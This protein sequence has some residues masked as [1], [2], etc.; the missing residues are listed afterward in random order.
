[1][2][3]FQKVGMPACGPT[4]SQDAIAKTSLFAFLTKKSIFIENQK[5]GQARDAESIQDENENGKKGERGNRVPL[6]FHVIEPP[7][8]PMNILVSLNS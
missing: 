5:D 7:L 4:E 2:A 6:P 8:G 1:M 3:I